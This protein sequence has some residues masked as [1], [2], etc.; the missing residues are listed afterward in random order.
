MKNVNIIQELHRIAAAHGGEL[1]P[2]DV[3]EA[4]KNKTSP[5]HSKFEWDDGEAAERYRLW[6]ARQLISVTVQYTGAEDNPILSR[7]FVS[8]TPDRGEANGYRTIQ[9]VMG[10]PSQRAQL[11]EDALQDMRRFQKKYSDLKELSELFKAMDSVKVKV[12]SRR[13]SVKDSAQV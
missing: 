2:V 10:N 11:L 6:Q 13:S 1:R 7:V 3:V 12:K 8:L 4:A 9:A 5:L